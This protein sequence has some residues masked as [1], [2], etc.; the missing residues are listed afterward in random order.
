MLCV[1]NFAAY[2][3]KVLADEK[4]GQKLGKYLPLEDSRAKMQKLKVFKVAPE[5]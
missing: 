2:E 4:G 5:P 3:R 1:A